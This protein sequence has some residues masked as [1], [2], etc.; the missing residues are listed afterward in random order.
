MAWELENTLIENLVQYL[1][2]SYTI[3]AVVIG[4]LT[5]AILL[6][7]RIEAKY[8]ILLVLPIMASFGAA[9]WYGE[10]SYIVSIALIAAAFIYGVALARFN[11]G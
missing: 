5:L 1:F 8:G 3:L 4:L 2:G 7:F 11:G 9:G 10:H 6:A